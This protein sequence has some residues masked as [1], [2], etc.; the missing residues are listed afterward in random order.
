MNSVEIKINALSI[1]VK[2]DNDY[3]LNRI[4]EQKHI[5]NLKIISELKKIF[6]ST[7]DDDLLRLYTKSISIHQSNVQGNGSFLENDILA[8]FLTKNNI[9]YKTQVT[10]DSEGI[11]TGFD[12][13]KKT[14]LS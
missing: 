9:S 8:P 4:K 14:M 10:I 11:I 12:G 13:K 2:F 5:K 7:S 3:V 6:P 1:D